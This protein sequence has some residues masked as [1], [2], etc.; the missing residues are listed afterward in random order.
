MTQL[1]TTKAPPNLPSSELHLP[2]RLSVDLNQI[3]ND[4]IKRDIA[5]DEVTTEDDD[6]DTDTPGNSGNDLT[7]VLCSEGSRPNI[8]KAWLYPQL[9]NLVAAAKGAAARPVVRFIKNL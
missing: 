5:N 1:T 6:V 9:E 2:H 4:E 8:G 3:P 7:A